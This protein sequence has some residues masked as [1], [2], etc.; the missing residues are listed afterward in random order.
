MPIKFSMPDDSAKGKRRLANAKGHTVEDTSKNSGLQKYT[1]SGNVSMPITRQAQYAGGGANIAMAQP[2]FFSPLHTPQNWQIASKRKEVFQWARFYYENEPKVAAGVDFY[3][4]DPSTQ[5]LMADG[6]QKAICAIKEGDLVRSHDGSVNVI[7]KVHVRDADETMLNIAFDASEDSLLVTENH[8]IFIYI[9]DKIQEISAKSL[10]EG[11]LLVYYADEAKPSKIRSIKSYDYA[12]KVYDLTVKNSHTYIANRVGV[13]NSQFSMNGFTLECKSA[14]IRKYFEELVKDLKLNYWLKLISHEY[15]LLGDVFPFLEIECKH[16]GGSGR[17]K[18]GKPCNHPDGKFKRLIILNPDYVEVEDSPFPDQRQL[19]L[20]PD[21]GLK[22]TVMTREPKH[23]Y[24]RLPDSI[25]MLIAA[26]QEIPLSSRSAS[27]IKHSETPYG[28]YGT[29]ILRR[30]FTTLAYKTKLM[31]ANWIVAERLVLPVRIVKIGDK[32]RP[33]GP[34]DIADMQQQMAAVAND[35]NLTIVTHHAFEYDWI[36]A[37]GKIHNITGEMDQIGKEILDGLMLNQALLNGE[38][39]GYSSAQMGVE[40]L[41]K[42]LDAWRNTLA[43]WVGEH[44]FKPTAMM[45]GFIDEEETKELGKTV[46]LYPTLKWNDLQLRDKTNKLQMFMQLFDKGLISAELLLEEF[47]IDYDQEIERIRHQQV[48]SSPGGVAGGAGGGMAGG[49]GAPGGGPPLDMGAAGGMPGG[50]PGGMP[51]GPGDMG[52]GMPGGA[53]GGAPGAPGGAPGGMGA[54]AETGG[55]VFKRGKAPKPGKQDDVP[56]TPPTFIKLTKIEQKVWRVLEDM[57][58]PF[59]IYG[60]YKQKV[61]GENQ[62]FV[63][64]FAVPELGI[65]VECLLPDQMVATSSGSQRAKDISIGSKLIGRNGDY[66]DVVNI[67]KHKNTTNMRSIKACG[68]LPIHVTDN[69]PVLV[70]KPKKMSMTSVEPR[71]T[72]QRTYIVPGEQ[73]FVDAGNINIGDFLVFPKEKHTHDLTTID[74][75]KFKTLGNL[76]NNIIPDEIVCNS[77]FAWLMGIYLAEGCVSGTSNITFSFHIEETEYINKVQNLLKNIFG[78]DSTVFLIPDE[79]VARV[80]A[81]S[82][83]LAAFLLESFGH[84]APSKH[85]PQWLNSLSDECLNEFMFGFMEG[86]GCERENGAQRYISSSVALLMDLQRTL[87][88]RGKFANLLCSRKPGTPC[89]FTKNGETREYITAGL[90]EL[91]FNPNR[92]KMQYWEDDNNYYLPVRKNIEYS[93]DGDVINFETSG[94]KDSN[95][96]YC[97]GNLVSHNCD[98]LIW[99]QQEGAPERDAERDRKLASYGWRIIR[100]TESAIN[101]NLEEVK[102]VMYDNIK[103]AAAERFSQRK[104]A[105]LIAN[106]KHASAEIPLTI[107]NAYYKLSEDAVVAEKRGSI[108]QVI[109]GVNSDTENIQ[110][111][112][113]SGP[114]EN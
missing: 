71:I 67:F 108:V 22:K 88:S 4:F 85:I 97:V 109:S 58:L 40:T 28:K 66:V 39:A 49:I 1:T 105:E 74:M 32:D 2:M 56:F 64:D 27:H 37:S 20:I 44:I 94:E 14:K 10:K 103:E 79:N 26:G 8:S 107:K 62:P 81:S 70:A 91:S 51:G 60:Q 17:T 68:M 16:C 9:D 55:K 38:A 21:E 77:D 114:E 95:H 42:R 19:K 112:Q 30:L 11:D 113:D 15:F 46:Y 29:S 75:R 24:D 25:K 7:E 102:Q 43:D 53:P 104:K 83:C 5:I 3:C 34:D 57:H 6:E 50:A 36:G 92:Q 61:Y 111:E 12:G 93:Y 100:F 65:N 96:T 99:H 82:I 13:H 86:D 59:K 35:P 18:S 90:W 78:L 89:S 110:P 47:G 33:A 31:T 54:A 80:T 76:R 63:M 73:S 98:G 106:I 41:I 45:Q 87:A 84:L 52:G 72:R 101:N 23:I 48:M 69:H